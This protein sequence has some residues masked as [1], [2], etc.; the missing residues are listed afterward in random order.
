MGKDIA[1]LFGIEKEER[2]LISILLIQSV[3]FG[4]FYGVFNITAHSLFLAKF[5]EILMARAYILSGLA[6]I[7]LTWLYT[8]FQSRMR[9]T[10]FVL[11]NFVFVM[12]LTLALWFFLVVSG[13][14]WVI[15]AIFIL[16]G[17]LNLLALLGFY[18]TTGRLFT[19]RQGRRLFGLVD[20]GIVVGVIISSFSIPAL[21]SMSVSTS[22]I[23]L[24][25]AVSILA[26]LIIQ[27]VIG[28]RYEQ[29]RVLSAS[30]EKSRASLAIFRNDSYI[31]S[32]GLF[33]AFSVI[34]AFFI[35][36]SFM[37]VT[38]ER[39]PL[40]ED[41]ASFLGMF[42]GT[43][44]VF[45]LL[46]KTF[47]FS[48]LIKNHGLKITLAVGPVLIGIF[49]VVAVVI[50]STMG[51]LPESGGFLVFF[52][53]LA[54]GRLFSKA[55]KDSLETPAFKVL[56]QTI[57][58]RLRYSVQS[59]IDGTINEFAA[60]ASGIILSILGA[61]SFIRLIHFSWV[62]LA[63]ILA[64]VY[65]AVKLYSQ[66][67][68]SVR[69]SIDT[70]EG[71]EDIEE[72]NIYEET[73]AGTLI[74]ITNNY[75]SYLDGESV[76]AK[77]ET[78]PV[79][80]ESFLRIAG[81]KHSIDLLPLIRRLKNSKLPADVT[82]RIKELE[83][84]LTSEIP[85]PYQNI[86]EG[87]IKAESRDK[88]VQSL[89]ASGNELM[90]TDLVKMIR[91]KDPVVRREAIYIAGKQEAAELIPDLC[92]CLS[93]SRVEKAAYSVLRSF[94]KKAFDT[95]TSHYY[96]AVGN[97]GV[98]QLI[99]RLFAETE[100]EQANPFLFERLW[101]AQRD[102]RMEALNGLVKCSFVPDED[103]KNKI[104]QEIHEVIGLLTWNIAA[105]VA[106]REKNDRLLLDSLNNESEW[107][108]DFLFALLE[109][110][111]DSRSFEKIK[112]NL[113]SATVESVNL[114]LE[115]IDIVVEEAV[116]PRLTALLDVSG[117]EEKLKNLFQFY[118]GEIP[119][120]ESLVIDLVNTDYNRIGVWTKACALKSLNSIENIEN[121]D[122]LVAL[123]FSPFLIL[124]EEA[125]RILNARFNKVLEYCRKRIPSQ[126][127]EHM[128]LMLEGK[129]S[130]KD[131]I[132]TKAGFLAELLPG[133]PMDDLADL[134]RDL[135]YTLGITASE[136]INNSFI[137]W[138]ADDASVDPVIRWNLAGMDSGY[139]GGEHSRNEMFTLSIETLI[140]KIFFKPTLSESIIKYLET[141]ITKNAI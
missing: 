77:L 3:F 7:A 86:S 114:A 87:I 60:L 13:S 40:E 91:D 118:P 62:L 15:F 83:E 38:R 34:V 68:N 66:Y 17:P 82:T 63:L 54:L 138:N 10:N 33:I 104:I 21:L 46:I 53:I 5:D 55:M 56:Y 25:S 12:L 39:Y 89:F 135:K 130:A 80:L 78:N 94:G 44:M 23:L 65:T 123:L 37:A 9:F 88:F 26:A 119:E 52:L 97:T 128:A 2:G 28:S 72:E 64:W 35:Q 133:I 58:E 134:A 20:T 120:Y 70:L 36:Y 132:F 74:E 1:R 4:I 18:G 112:S 85:V 43:M 6:G 49:V 116:K 105:S 99:I 124:R 129:L 126:Y 45:T 139:Q 100:S 75:Y 93:V 24:I 22:G 109:L 29:L 59:A 79:L 31:R 127:M 81:E 103:Q 106:L 111:Y 50:G 73:I 32:M 92:D 48:Y 141:Y 71:K 57:S 102:L 131:E 69:K 30:Q 125:F 47:I 42:E 117:D 121:P 76:A 107:W 51:Y 95:M 14:N 84:S 136:D 113:E 11:L 16:M 98:R 108:M 140:T 8:R 90:I 110:I 27:S 96:R 101:A 115:M 41:L 122:F 137:A 19:L 67:R 61:L